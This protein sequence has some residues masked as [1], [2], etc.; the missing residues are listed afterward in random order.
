M[1]TQR[2]LD[3]LIRKLDRKMILDWVPEMRL[4]KA[5]YDYLV[6]RLQKGDLTRNQIAN[7]LHALFRLRAHGSEEEVFALLR[8]HAIHREIRVRNEA[9]T[10]LI[11]MMKLHKLRPPFQLVKCI[12]ELNDAL[13]LGLS[14]D[15]SFLSRD[16]IAKHRGK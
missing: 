13:V 16:L 6:E 2:E 14:P 10:L 1:A 9:V 12:S 7:A 5:A 3:S 15:A 11:G 8:K 4:G